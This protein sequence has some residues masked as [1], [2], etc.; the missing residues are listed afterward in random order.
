MSSLENFLQEASAGLPV[1]V[2]APGNIANNLGLATFLLGQSNY[3]YFGTSN[4]W[5]D[6][7][8][9]WH[10]EYDASYGSPLGPA[11]RNASGWHREFSRCSV[12]LRADGR[13]ATIAMHSKSV[14]P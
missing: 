8:W 1:V 10:V 12:S 6:G 13:V 5:T 4:G 3:T 2:H 11:K 14:E 9:V 7:G